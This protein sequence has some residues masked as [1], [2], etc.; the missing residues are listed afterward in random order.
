MGLSPAT[1][2]APLVGTRARP[3][4]AGPIPHATVP[5]ARGARPDSAL[6]RSRFTRRYWGNPGW[7]PFLRLVKCFNSAGSP[8][9]SEAGPERENRGRGGGERADP[10][11]RV[12][13]ARTPAASQSVPLA[14]EPSEGVLPGRRAGVR[15]RG[16]RG[17]RPEPVEGRAFSRRLRHCRRRRRHDSERLASPLRSGP[18]RPRRERRRRVGGG[19]RERTPGRA[20][21][22]RARRPSA[23]GPTA[24]PEY[25]R[26]LRLRRRG[27]KSTRPAASRPLRDEPTLRRTWLRGPESRYVRSRCR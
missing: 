22:A 26:S 6:G 4:P 27:A 16:G 23:A 20:S 21:L 11:T 7:F 12:P 5:T 19:R 17:R 8:A 18:S 9:R 25:P 14:T 2:R 24:A 15:G 1:V 3:D 10:W 13:D